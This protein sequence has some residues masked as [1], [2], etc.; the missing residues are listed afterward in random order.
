MNCL[1]T[2]NFILSL[3]FIHNFDELKNKSKHNIT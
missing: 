3:H 2:A 1:Y